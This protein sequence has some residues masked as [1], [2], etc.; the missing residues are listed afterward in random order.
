MMNSYAIAVSREPR[1]GEWNGLPDQWIDGPTTP[2]RSTLHHRVVETLGVR[3]VRG[4]IAVGEV[5]P[6][7]QGLC[8]QLNVSRTVLREGIKTLS[9]KGLVEAKTKVGTTVRPREDWNMLD[10]DFISWRLLHADRQQA[11]AELFDMRLIF[12]PVAAGRAAERATEAEIAAIAT[13]YEEMNNRARQQQDFIEPDIVFHC[14]ILNASGNQFLAGLG[15]LIAAGLRLIFRQ[16]W[17]R[18]ESLDRAMGEHQ[19][20]FDHI[21]SGDAQRAEV[22]MRKLLQNARS[23]WRRVEASR[24]LQDPAHDR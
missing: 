15:N 16:S 24:V 19:V 20:V 4:D 13:A 18:P 2:K 6:N 14:R 7:E 21:R 12:E 10:P 22:A 23:D 8:V 1:N 17:S 11:A 3:I 5:L 9:A